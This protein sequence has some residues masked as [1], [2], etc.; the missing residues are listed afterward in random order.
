MHFVA[1]E[2]ACKP[3]SGR[4]VE[5]VL[6]TWAIETHKPTFDPRQVHARGNN[7]AVQVEEI[8]ESDGS[9]R[10]RYKMCCPRCGATPVVREDK[11]DAGL[12]AMY[13]PGAIARTRRVHL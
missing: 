3:C 6:G 1:L 5:T 8:L 7:T 11:V 2:V 4:G 9:Y 13:E 10:R 12:E